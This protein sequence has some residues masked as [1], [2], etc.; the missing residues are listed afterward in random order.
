MQM[1]MLPW[2]SFTSLTAAYLGLF[3]FKEKHEYLITV[4]LALYSYAGTCRVHVNLENT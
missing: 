3:I 4:V 2:E 1:T